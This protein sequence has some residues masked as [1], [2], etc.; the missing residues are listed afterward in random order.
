MSNEGTALGR[1]LMEENARR[2]TARI[3]HATFACVVSGKNIHDMGVEAWKACAEYFDG[4]DFEIES[5]DAEE[6][7]AAEVRVGETFETQP[8]GPVSYVARV[9]ARAV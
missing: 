3:P 8:V 4:Q 5:L 2:A 1:A 6:I 9:R 7:P